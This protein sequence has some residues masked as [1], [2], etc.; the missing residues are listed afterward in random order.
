MS[1]RF[2]DKFNLLKHQKQKNLK[3]KDLEILVAKGPARSFL[4]RNLEIVDLGA[5]LLEGGC[6]AEHRRVEINVNSALFPNLNRLTYFEIH[7]VENVNISGLSNF[8]RKYK[9]LEF[10]IQ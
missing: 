6:V 5:L 2:A 4:S 8:R 1:H 3:L 7:F 9:V 10:A